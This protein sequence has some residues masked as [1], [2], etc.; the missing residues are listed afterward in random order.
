MAAQ[1][2]REIQAVLFFAESAFQSGPEHSHMYFYLEQQVGLAYN[3][4]D[5]LC[6]MF[7][8][9]L[10]LGLGGGIRF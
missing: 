7:N 3:M 1:A 5:G 9:G 10:G 4:D 6:L 8:L 2:K